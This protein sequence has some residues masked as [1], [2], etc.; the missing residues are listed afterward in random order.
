[1]I[2][3][4][5]AASAPPNRPP[6]VGVRPPIMSV[7]LRL[8]SCRDEDKEMGQAGEMHPAARAYV[9]TQLDILQLNNDGVFFKPPATTNGCERQPESQEQKHPSGS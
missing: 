5:I 7:L 8:I 1:M 4:A 2:A 6:E 3:A 9:G